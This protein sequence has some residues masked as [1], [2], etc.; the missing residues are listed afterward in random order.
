MSWQFQLLFK[1]YGGVTEGQVWDGEAVYF[2]H[3]PTSRI[4]K[5][6]PVSGQITEARGGTNHTNGLAGAA[7]SFRP[8]Y[9][10]WFISGPHWGCRISKEP[11]RRT[12]LLE[13]V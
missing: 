8:V 5:Y 13:I 9:F 10:G 11:A 1:P 4:M 7:S 12:M 2:S 3:I 6:D